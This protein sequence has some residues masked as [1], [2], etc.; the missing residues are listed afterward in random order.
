MMN[1]EIIAF[2][3]T[4]EILSHGNQQVI[5]LFRSGMPEQLIEAEYNISNDVFHLGIS[6]PQPIELINYE[7]RKGIIFNRVVGITMLKSITKKLWTVNKEAKRM[8]RIHCRIHQK[9]VLNFPKQKDILIERI[10]QA[11]IISS[12]EKERI[13]TNL[14]DLKDDVKLCHGDYHPDNIILGEKEWIIDWMTGMAGNPAGDVART[15]LLLKLGSMPDK[16]PK[17]IKG[18]VSAIRNKILKT[19]IKEY[20]KNSELTIEEI[21]QWIVPVATARLCEWIPEKE[22]KVLVELIRRSSL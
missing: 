7:D 20:T 2:G 10:L 21:N 5:K 9:S 14:K 12:K 19:Y 15:I 18:L 1:A 3:R 11:P 6:C 16:T 17:I 22:K 13:I 4:A 8:A